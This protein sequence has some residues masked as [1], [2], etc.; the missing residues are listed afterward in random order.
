MEQAQSL[1][2][3]NCA[4]VSQG[5]LKTSAAVGA[6][7]L[8]VCVCKAGRRAVVV[9]VAICGPVKGR[10]ESGEEARGADGGVVRGSGKRWPRGQKERKGGL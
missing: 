1:L 3:Q 2:R 4:A 9:A 6:S 8:C 10:D 7:W 5:C